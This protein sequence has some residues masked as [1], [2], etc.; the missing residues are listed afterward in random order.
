MEN[1][2]IKLGGHDYLGAAQDA[3]RLFNLI[4]LLNNDSMKKVY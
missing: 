3:Y 2:Y 4:L 1:I